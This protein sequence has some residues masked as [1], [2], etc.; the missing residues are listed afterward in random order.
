MCCSQDPLQSPFYR[1]E[2]HWQLPSPLAQQ[3]SVVIIIQLGQQFCSFTFK[4]LSTLG[5]TPSSPSDLLT[6]NL[7]IW[8]DFSFCIYLRLVSLIYWLQKVHLVWERPQ[9]LQQLRL[10]ILCYGFTNSK[11]PFYTF[12][13]KHSPRY[14]NP[15]GLYPN[16][17]NTYVLMDI[18]SKVLRSQKCSPKTDYCTYLLSLLCPSSCHPAFP[19]WWRFQIPQ[20]D[21]WDSM[22]HHGSQ[23]RFNTGWRSQH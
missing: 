11:W 20:R 12:V 10:Y 23:L 18:K 9:Y 21:H 3:P 1:W 6:S 2:L 16:V 7:S 4:F 22:C 5:W 19:S 17:Y 13:I 15:N 8:T 14:P